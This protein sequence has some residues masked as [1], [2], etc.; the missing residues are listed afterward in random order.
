MKYQRLVNSITES[1]IKTLLEKKGEKDD[2][3]TDDDTSNNTNTNSPTF[4]SKEKKA[5]KFL[6]NPMIDCAEVYHKAF[7]NDYKDGDEDTLRSYNNKCK[8]K[9][10]DSNGNT[11]HFT[12]EKLNSILSVEKELKR[13]L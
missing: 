9:S 10:K 5:L 11:C 4:L 1:V 2:E 6:D 12:M 13:S 3:T 7:K 8:N